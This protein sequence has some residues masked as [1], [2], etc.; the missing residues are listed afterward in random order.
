MTV[1]FDVRPA[2]RGLISLIVDRAE[3]L[4][5]ADDHILDRVST[6]MDL[7]ACH[8]NGCP[9]DLIKLVAADNATVSHDVFGIARHLDRSTGQLRDFFLPRCALPETSKEAA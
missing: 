9:L 6:A 8:A 5:L 2:E 1:S 3:E 7:T 4:A